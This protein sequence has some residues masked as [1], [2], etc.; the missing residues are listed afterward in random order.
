MDGNI[1]SRR[2]QHDWCKRNKRQVD[3]SLSLFTVALHK[4]REEL[5]GVEAGVDDALASWEGELDQ[6]DAGGGGA[7]HLPY[8]H[9]DKMGV[10]E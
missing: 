1:C 6:G 10:N 9:L 3:E 8:Y 2:R 4:Q 7:V 5:G